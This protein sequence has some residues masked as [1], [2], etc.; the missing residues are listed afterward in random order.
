MSS[1][2]VRSFPPNVGK[3][4]CPRYYYDARRQTCRK[5][6]YG[7][8]G[9]NANNFKSKALC[10]CVGYQGVSASNFVCAILDETDKEVFSKECLLT[11][12][13]KFSNY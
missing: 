12:A 8:C 2:V 1:G 5:L 11:V 7:C 4:A 9:G 3:G 6:N 10:L 13:I